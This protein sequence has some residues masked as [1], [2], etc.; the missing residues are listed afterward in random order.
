VV[1]NPQPISALLLADHLSGKNPYLSLTGEVFT[2]LR[3]Y[4]RPQTELLSVLASDTPVYLKPD[5]QLLLKSLGLKDKDFDRTTFIRHGSVTSAIIDQAKKT[6][7]SLVIVGAS[8]PKLF[9]EI[10]FGSIPELL[11]K[12]LNTSLMI[13]RGHQGMAKAI[14]QRLLRK[15]S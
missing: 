14:W 5:P 9:Q 7:A 10:R 15:A 8:K 4:Y 6:N 3:N 12:H 13:V 1:K 2:A 11:A